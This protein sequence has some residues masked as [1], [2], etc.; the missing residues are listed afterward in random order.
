MPSHHPP[1]EGKKKA[2]HTPKEK[3]Q[4]KEQKKRAGQSEPLIKQG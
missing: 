1:K 3:K 4:M 2:Q